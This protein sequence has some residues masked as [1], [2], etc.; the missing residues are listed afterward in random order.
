MSSNSVPWSTLT[1][2]AF[3]AFASSPSSLGASVPASAA[4]AAAA[5][6]LS[7]WNL[8]YSITLDRI[9]E[10]TLGSGTGESTPVSGGRP[11]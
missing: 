11:E 5:A 3:H 1:N 2:S 6:G 9:L 7:T 4:P 8:A 10:V